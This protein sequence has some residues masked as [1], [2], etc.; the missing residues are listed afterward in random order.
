MRLKASAAA[1]VHEVPDAVAVFD[2]AGELVGWDE[3]AAHAFLAACGLPSDCD[4]ECATR[5]HID[6]W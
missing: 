4:A 5:G 6:L 2:E 1:V 3:S